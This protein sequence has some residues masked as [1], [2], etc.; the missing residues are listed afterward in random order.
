MIKLV[1]VPIDVNGPIK[2]GK[3]INVQI[4]YTNSIPQILVELHDKHEYLD[5]GDNCS[6]TADI[7]NTDLV[8]TDFTGTI[9]VKNPHRGQLSILLNKEDFSM[10]GINT[11]TVVCGCENYTYSFQLPVYVQT[12]TKNISFPITQ[13]TS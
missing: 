12:I 8:I 2:T 7:T 6:I 11:L 10:T 9:T 13:T 1:Y 3:P 5:L 4:G